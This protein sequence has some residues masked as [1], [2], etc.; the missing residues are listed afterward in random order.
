MIKGINAPDSNSSDDD[1][2]WVSQ[3]S[4]MINPDQWQNAPSNRPVS[5]AE[6]RET[7]PLYLQLHLKVICILYCDHPSLVA[8]SFEREKWG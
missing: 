3:L 8:L 7:F 4:F 2:D 1:S 5:Q 6:S